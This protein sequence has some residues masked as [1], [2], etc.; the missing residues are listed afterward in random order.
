M[1]RIARRALFSLAAG[2]L[3][4]PPVF[5][6]RAPRIGI[7]DIAGRQVEVPLG[8]RRIVLGE[9]RLLYGTVLLDKDDPFG[10]IAAWG[11]DMRLFDPDAWRRYRARFPAMTRV[12][13]VG[14]AV[15]GDFSVEQVIALDADC[16]IFPI[17]AQRRV[18]DS[19]IP[20][21]LA[22]AGIPAVFV[23]LREQLLRNTVPSLE[24][25][26]K[27]M[28]RRDAARDFVAFY[29]EQSGRVRD[30]VRDLP[31][32]AKPLVF[33]EQ[34]AGFDPNQCCRTWAHANLGALVPEAGGRNWGTPRFSGSGGMVNP[35]AILTDDPD[36]II[37]TGA[38]WAETRP[39]VTSV[40]LGYD[41]TAAE[42]QR[43][44]AALAARPIFAT[45]KATR[46]GRF[47]SIHHQFYTSPLHVVAL[48]A[49]AGWMH[50]ERFRDLDPEATHRDL[51]ARFLPI[52][53]G[54][55]FWATLEQPPG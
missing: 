5:A 25:L 23:D 52:P 9:G 2:A 19:S 14:S 49:F 43:R 27:I 26:G 48:Q 44:L 16:V 29:E 42:V 22:R 20:E 1:T 3:A 12:P 8:A 41:A 10:R 38:N 45:L 24:I 46:A 6:Q 35:E 28:D 32:N 21:R 55:I 13:E 40:L 17:S 53:Y 11:N 36:V 15:A 34:A 30:R 4:A 54:G 7:T 33:L 47:H 31:E 37:G 39:E 18:Q 51:H 50:P